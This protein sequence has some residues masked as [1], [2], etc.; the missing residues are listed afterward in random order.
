MVKLPQSPSQIGTRFNLFTRNNR[1]STTLI[2]DHNINKLTASHFKISRRTILVIHGFTGKGKRW[3]R[4]GGAGGEG[5]DDGRDRWIS[6]IYFSW[7]PAT[8][9]FD[10]PPPPP[11]ITPETRSSPLIHLKRTICRTILSNFKQIL[12]KLPSIKEEVPTCLHDKS[13]HSRPFWVN[14]LVFLD[15]TSLFYEQMLICE[16]LENERYKAKVMSFIPISCC[17]IEVT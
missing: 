17:G 8:Q 15:F 2:D 5:Q 13:F 4:G 1:N 10:C 12:L 6:F 11:S 16:I 9:A 7:T 3:W 14:M